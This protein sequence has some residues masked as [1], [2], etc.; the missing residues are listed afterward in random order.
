MLLIFQ[1]T[2]FMVFLVNLQIIIPLIMLFIRR[3]VWSCLRYY[4]YYTYRA[5]FTYF[6]SIMHNTCGIFRHKLRKKS[7]SDTRNRKKKRKKNEQK[8]GQFA[9]HLPVK[10]SFWSYDFAILYRLPLNNLRDLN[11]SIMTTFFS[12]FYA[13]ANRKPTN[14]STQQRETNGDPSTGGQIAS[15]Q[16]VYLKIFLR[17]ADRIELV[18]S[19]YN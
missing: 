11:V 7:Q 9:S 17:P 19:Q 13:R 5:N 3:V 18:D 1:F 8:N 16:I 14:N 15:L 12:V 4:R 2:L 6:Y 10:H